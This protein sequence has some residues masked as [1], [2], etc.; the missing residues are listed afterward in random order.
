MN[1]RAQVHARE[2]QE[3]EA[4][5]SR[6]IA[7]REA[8]SRPRNALEAMARRLSLSPDVL[9]NT[10]QKTAFSGCRTNEEFVALI[11]VANEYALNPLLKEIYAFPAKGGGIV[12]MVGYDGWVKLMNNHPQFD[13]IEYND[14]LDSKGNL[15]GIECVIYRKDRRHPIKLMELL[16]EC[17][18]G[19]EPWKMMPSRMLRNRVTCQAAR[20]AFGFSGIASEGDEDTFIDGGALTAQSLPS[21]QSF[22]QELDDEIP[23]F[24]KQTGE[25]IEQDASGRSVEDE[26]TARALDAGEPTEA[27]IAEETAQAIDGPL[28]ED[29]KP[30]WFDLVAEIRAGLNAAKTKTYFNELDNKFTNARAGLPDDVIAELDKLTAAARKRVANSEV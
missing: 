11:A 13:G 20:L 27:E 1:V 28:P 25:V 9:R 15:Y 19:T 12:P 4:S 22:A 6:A 2:A 29:S 5:Q 14:H 16:E 3:I 23:N 7:A 8:E 24:D 17:R 10:L 18:R 21:R 30:A 26:E